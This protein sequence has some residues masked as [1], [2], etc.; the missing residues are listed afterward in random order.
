MNL[1]ESRGRFRRLRGKK[2]G[3]QFSI[4]ANRSDRASSHA[5]LKIPGRVRKKA[6]TA[7]LQCRTFLRLK[8]NGVPQRKDFGGRYGFPGFS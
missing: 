1:G 8:K 7:L 6:Y 3:S 5:P 2:A 4:R